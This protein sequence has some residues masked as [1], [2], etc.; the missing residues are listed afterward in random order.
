MYRP[1]CIYN[2]HRRDIGLILAL[3]S[4]YLYLQPCQLNLKLENC[5]TKFLFLLRKHCSQGLRKV[6]KSGGWGA[7]S[8]KLFLSAS[9]LFSILAK[10]GEALAPLILIIFKYCRFLEL[11]GTLYNS[12]AVLA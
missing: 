10:S 4:T 3:P 1:V 9:I 2:L 5:T 11:E 12:G 8:N 7:N 6:Q